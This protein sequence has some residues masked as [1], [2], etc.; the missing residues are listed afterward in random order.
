MLEMNNKTT[1]NVFFFNKYGKFWSILPDK[2]VDLKPLFSKEW[3]E[4]IL[5]VDYFNLNFWAKISL[6]KHRVIENNRK[7][8]GVNNQ[9][10]VLHKTNFKMAK[11]IEIVQAAKAIYSLFGEKKMPFNI[12]MYF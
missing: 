12:L 8:T 4:I 10:V 9:I 2:K 3:H 1:E 5:W 11:T 7:E 6:Q